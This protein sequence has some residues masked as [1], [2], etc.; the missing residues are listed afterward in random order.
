MLLASGS[1]GSSKQSAWNA[2]R[3]K[4]LRR[5]SAGGTEILAPI[6]GDP[7]DVD[8]D[9]M[10]DATTTT[11]T[12]AAAAAETADAAATD[13]GSSNGSNKSSG[14]DGGCDATATTLSAS[15]ARFRLK[16]GSE[17]TLTRGLHQ[18]GGSGNDG[19]GM[20]ALLSRRRG[21]LPVEMLSISCSG[22]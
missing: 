15:A 17:V 22:E 21:S 4:L 6:F 11:T 2:S 10:D 16:R 13:S 7:L 20:E 1:R 19:G 3:K 18:R 8:I 5:R 9:D 14:G 12:A